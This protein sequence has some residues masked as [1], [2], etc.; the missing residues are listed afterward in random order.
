MIIYNVTLNI[1]ESIEQEWLIWMR[2]VHIPEVMNTGKFISCRLSKLI[3]HQEKG[4]QNYS[5]QYT[6]HSTRDLKE[7]QQ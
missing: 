5:A 6:C 2:D 3:S 4:S 7:Y 1:E